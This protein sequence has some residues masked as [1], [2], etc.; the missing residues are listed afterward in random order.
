MWDNGKMINKMDMEYNNGL[1]D[2][3]TRDN[4]KTVLKQEKEY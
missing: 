2:K 4:I 3:S 1:M